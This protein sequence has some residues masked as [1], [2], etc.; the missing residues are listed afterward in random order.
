M[1]CLET[2]RNEV[3]E[4]IICTFMPGSS[5]SELSDE[6]LLIEGGIIDSGGALEFVLF[7]EER[8]RISIP[9]EELLVEN[10]ATVN[11]VVDFITSKL[12]EKVAES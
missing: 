1:L 2:I 6:D 5:P 12:E 4:F 11:R 7:L 8:Y 9:D 3:R 10:F